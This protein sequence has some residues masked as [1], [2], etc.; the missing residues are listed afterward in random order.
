MPLKREDAARAI[1]EMR[2]RG[3]DDNRI[4]LT[5]TQMGG[6]EPSRQETEAGRALAFKAVDYPSNLARGTVGTAVQQFTDKDLGVDLLKTLKGEAPTTATML[7]RGGVG[8][9]GRLSDVLGPAV[10]EEPGKGSWLKLD[11]GGPL[12]ITGR[13]AVGFVGD[14]AG[15]FGVLSAMNK[16]AKA[17]KA[18]AMIANSPKRAALEKALDVAV[19]PMS[20]ASKDLGEKLYTSGFKKLDSRL[21]ERGEDVVAPY[22]LKQGVWGTMRGIEKG[23]EKRLAELAPMREAAYNEANKLGVQIAEEDVVKP[24]LNYLDLK[25]VNPR[26]REEIKPMREYVLSGIEADPIKYASDMAE[27]EAAKAAYRRDMR[28]WVTQERGRRAA[29][30]NVGQQSVLGVDEASAPTGQIEMSGLDPNKIV[31][32]PP[33]PVDP[34]DDQIKL[35]QAQRASEFT[36][37]EIDNLLAQRQRIVDEFGEP[38]SISAAIASGNTNSPSMEFMLPE[39][40]GNPN[41][42]KSDWLP[43]NNGRVDAPKVALAKKGEAL[44]RKRLDA[45]IEKEQQFINRR[46]GDAISRDGAQQPFVVLEKPTR[47]PRPQLSTK[48][49]DVTEASRRK[50]ELYDTLPGQYFDELGRPTTFGK[51]TNAK[52]AQGYRTEIIDK[53]NAA[54]AGLGDKIDEINKE[55]GA[56]L[57]ARKPLRSEV[58]KEARKDAQT[59]VDIMTLA[60]MPFVWGA[61]Q[62]GKAWNAPLVRTGVGLGMHRAGEK[63]PEAAWRSILLAPGR[64]EDEEQKPVPWR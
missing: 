13:G 34:I 45:A 53:S 35:L 23:A 24:A 41:M 61:K 6:V 26:M 42:K 21:V 46:T 9:M 1:E 40:S 38:E 57:G 16:G 4:K 20:T 32:R 37:G 49:I 52:L 28:N 14:A 11:R 62:V 22:A 2:K 29:E 55:W 50:S 8:E 60:G 56:W 47:P 54:Q 48:K 43:P 64:D 5:L 18:S 7:Q 15:D 39:F 3:W 58:A 19:N 12:D 25:A 30:K 63:I 27:Y 44:N 31:E 36:K 10:Y 59:Q 51:D 17:L 33:H